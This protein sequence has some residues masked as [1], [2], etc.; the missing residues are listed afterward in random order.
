MN[1]YEFPS[2]LEMAEALHEHSTGSSDALQKERELKVYEFLKMRIRE[3]QPTN[4]NAT[5]TSRHYDEAVYRLVQASITEY[6]TSPW[7]KHSPVATPPFVCDCGHTHFFIYV[8]INGTYYHCTH[9][10]RNHSS[11]S[12]SQTP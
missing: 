12:A 6:E 5:V 9:C 7:E 2:L 11:T 4:I 1:R 3:W 10:G 8:G